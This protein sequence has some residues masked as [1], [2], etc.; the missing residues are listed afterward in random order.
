M[1]T[2]F[3][4]G[5]AGS[6]SNAAHMWYDFYTQV[7]GGAGLAAS[8]IPGTLNGIT[9]MPSGFAPNYDWIAY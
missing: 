2:T 6:A 1:N 9:F 8:L 4:T 3:T 5:G 7:A